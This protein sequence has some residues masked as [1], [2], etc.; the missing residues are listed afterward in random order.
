MDKSRGSREERY[1][2][3]YVDNRCADA[4]STTSKIGYREDN[5]AWVAV[6][7]MLGK[8]LSIS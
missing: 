2:V 6:K 3:E 1:E 7:I 5:Q 4:R 8:S